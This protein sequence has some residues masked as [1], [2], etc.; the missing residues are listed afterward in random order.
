MPRIIRS[1]AK[2]YVE[3]GDERYK[4]PVSLLVFLDKL[5]YTN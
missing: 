1:S 2:D 5:M 3:L 4:N